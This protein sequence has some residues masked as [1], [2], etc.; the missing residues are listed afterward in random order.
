MTD[1]GQRLG[2]GVERERKLNSHA[3]VQGQSPGHPPPIPP[4]KPPLY[5]ERGR[6][7]EGGILTVGHW[8]VTRSSGH[9]LLGPPSLH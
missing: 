5:T 3:D 2:F 4:P 6:Q 9:W 8:A 1:S 7:G